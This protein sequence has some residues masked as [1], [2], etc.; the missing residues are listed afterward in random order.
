MQEQFFPMSHKLLSPKFVQPI[1][2]EYIALTYDH[3][4]ERAN[5]YNGLNVALR[6][7]IV[8]LTFQAS[9][10]AF[11][12]QHCPVDDLF[13]PFKIFDDGF[14]L[15]LAGVPKMFLKAQV[16]ALDHMA[17]I[18]EE[19]YL[20]KPTAMDE[21]CDMVKEYDRMVKEAG[22]VS[23]YPYTT[24]LRVLT[25]RLAGKQRCRKTHYHIPLGPPGEC[26]T[27]S[28]L[29]YRAQPPTTGRPRTAGQRG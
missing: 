12:G 13:K 16:I 25:G 15:I 24:F 19:E 6:D 17:T 20:S 7:F 9:G 5:Q 14:H 1:V 11:F 28:L 3:L 18:I 26:T 4:E 21:A 23:S 8:P 29:D 22:Y 27:R 2:D 10:H